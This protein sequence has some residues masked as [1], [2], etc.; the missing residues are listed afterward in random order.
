MKKWFTICMYLVLIITVYVFK[1]EILHWMQHGDAPLLLIFLAALGF[2][3]VPVIP[4]KIVIGMLGF[5]YGPLMG[6]LISWTAASI[7]SVIVFWLARYL[8]QKQGRAYL[9]KYEKLEKLQAAIEKNPFL[10]I[11]L[12]RL[13][14]VIPQAVVNVIPAI[15]SVPVVTFA[16]A[17][18]LGKIPAMLLFAFIGSN[19]FAGTSKLVLSVGV[20]I[21]FLASVYIVYR[22]WLKKRWV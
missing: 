8:F 21:L 12:A 5:M 11:L 20:Y 13:I 15:T 10:T 16:V 6:A 7:A 19:L 18:A 14:P 3:I 2:I 9:S 22:V 4:Y 17:S 1:D